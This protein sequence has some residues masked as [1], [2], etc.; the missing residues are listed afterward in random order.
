MTTSTTTILDFVNI[1]NINEI[2]LFKQAKFLIKY[3]SRPALKGT[4]NLKRTPTKRERRELRN[5]EKAREAREAQRLQQKAQMDQ[6]AQIT[7]EEKYKKLR[8]AYVGLETAYV[9]LK[10]DYKTS[11][12]YKTKYADLKKDYAT[13]ED[14]FKDL[15]G[16]CNI[17]LRR[18]KTC[19]KDLEEKD[20]QIRKT[21]ERV[22]ELIEKN[23]ALLQNVAEL[24]GKNNALLQNVTKLTATKYALITVVEQ[25]DPRRRS[26][27]ESA[28]IKNDPDANSIQEVRDELRQHRRKTTPRKLDFAQVGKGSKK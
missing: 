23:D 2:A 5:R 18:R 12:K 24:I 25:L 26:L 8:E 11:K 22:A 9:G 7:T 4:G 20:Q 28:S 13:L 17:L 14:E 10:A 16:T 6:E 1:Q 19:K 27:Q 21:E 3:M 15:G